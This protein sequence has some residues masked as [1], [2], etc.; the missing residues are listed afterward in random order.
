MP[1]LLGNRLYKHV[2][3]T[4]SFRIG[5]I[6]GKTK[7]VIVDFETF[8]G[9]NTEEV[10]ENND[11][12]IKAII[13]SPISEYV[14]NAVAFF[15]E[16]I[17]TRNK[18][19][20]SSSLIKL[21]E[22]IIEKMPV[23]GTKIKTWLSHALSVVLEFFSYITESV[24]NLIKRHATNVFRWFSDKFHT[25][26]QHI[27]IIF[28]SKSVIVHKFVTGPLNLTNSV[29]HQ[30][31]IN[32]M[33]L[34]FLTPQTLSS[35]PIP[36]T[37]FKEMLDVAHQLVC[38]IGM[39]GFYGAFD[40]IY[41]MVINHARKHIVGLVVNLAK[42]INTLTNEE[43]LRA[44]PEIRKFFI[45]C[46]LTT[47]ARNGAKYN[48]YKT[49]PYALLKLLI[50]DSLR[51]KP[52]F[53][54]FLTD[55]W[56]WALQVIKLD[57]FYQNKLSTRHLWATMSPFIALINAINH[58]EHGQQ[59]I[60]RLYLINMIQDI[61]TTHMLMNHFNHEVL[62]F[63]KY[64]FNM[65][66][67]VDNQNAL[68]KEI[69][70]DKGGR[71]DLMDKLNIHRAFDLYHANATQKQDKIGVKKNPQRG[72]TKV[73]IAASSTDVIPE[74]PEEKAETAMGL[75][76]KPLEISTNTA[77][78]DKLSL[79]SRG[80]ATVEAQQLLINDRTNYDKYILAMTRLVKANTYFTLSPAVV[81]EAFSENKQYLIDQIQDN[82]ISD[83]MFDI[84]LQPTIDTYFFEYAFDNIEDELENI[85]VSIL[86]NVTLLASIQETIEAFYKQYQYIM[87]TSIS[88]L[89]HTTSSSGIDKIV[90]YVTDIVTEKCVILS[91]QCPE[92]WSVVSDVALKSDG[93]EIGTAKAHQYAD[94][95][96][97]DV[98]KNSHWV[99]ARVDGVMAK[100]SLRLF[101]DLNKYDMIAKKI[102]NLIDI[103]STKNTI[104]DN[105]LVVANTFR[106][107]SLYSVM[108]SLHFSQPN[109]HESS[110]HTHIRKYIRDVSAEIVTRSIEEKNVLQK[111]VFYLMDLNDI[112][113]YKDMVERVFQFSTL[114]LGLSA[115]SSFMT[116]TDA[117]A[118]TEN[119][120]LSFW[121]QAHTTQAMTSS[122]GIS[123][124][125]IYTSS[126]IGVLVK[127]QKMSNQLYSYLS[128]P[129]TLSRINTD[130]RELI[131]YSFTKILQN[132]DNPPSDALR[133][134]MD[135]TMRPFSA[136]GF[137]ATS[138]SL[139]WS[140][141]TFSPVMLLING[142]T[143]GT[144]GM[145]ME[146]VGEYMFPTMKTYADL[147]AVN[148]DTL[149]G[150]EAIYS[151][152][153][154]V[155]ELKKL[156]VLN[157]K[158]PAAVL[159]QTWWDT[160]VDTVV[161]APGAAIK[162]IF[163]NNNVVLAEASNGVDRL[164]HLHEIHEKVKWHVTLTQQISKSFYF[165][166]PRTDVFS[167]VFKA[168][169][170]GF[171]GFLTNLYAI[172]MAQDFAANNIKFYWY[173]CIGFIVSVCILCFLVS[174]FVVSYYGARNRFS[175]LTKE[176]EKIYRLL[177][178]NSSIL[179]GDGHTSNVQEAIGPIISLFD[180]LFFALKTVTIVALVAFIKVMS[181]LGP[182]MLIYL[183]WVVYSIISDTMST[184]WV[185]IISF[186]SL[187]FIASNIPILRDIDIVSRIIRYVPCFAIFM[188][189][190]VEPFKRKLTGI[191][192]QL[193][194]TISSVDVRPQVERAFEEINAFQ[195]KYSTTNVNAI[196][197]QIAQIMELYA[198]SINDYKKFS[199]ELETSSIPND[200]SSYTTN[201]KIATKT[202]L[203]RNEPK[204]G[205]TSNVIVETLG[206]RKPIAASSSEPM[207]RF[208]LNN[209]TIELQTFFRAYAKN[210]NLRISLGLNNNE[211]TIAGPAS[212]SQQQSL[213]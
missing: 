26:F 202:L 53:V 14:D 10:F 193:R 186:F 36:D 3:K 166:F 179:S 74:E 169:F 64:L 113:L 90:Q 6:F 69:H 145:L 114:G 144:A 46:F 60:N 73:P 105:S 19:T 50:K 147:V 206:T 27:L 55:L 95:E 7:E 79:I 124:F 85:D 5:E 83:L 209:A 33:P 213:K 110:L 142:A 23:V 191:T 171:Y 200:F 164:K 162:W 185:V 170:Q 160:I 143:G 45:N 51:D 28:K 78:N 161:S 89:H 112:T 178:V 198:T 29:F 30:N 77:L 87:K 165:N 176:R 211:L 194:T 122:D 172:F 68:L 121:H 207:E 135:N 97:F 173:I 204:V 72:K 62:V 1:K 137:A 175:L 41:G 101:N 43:C 57:G 47:D 96:R 131:N 203:Q 17:T 152:T 76:L 18:K 4:N 188:D 25:V 15:D 141:M 100:F 192:Q 54:R 163:S 56:A 61:K 91:K 205:W 38:Y 167:G 111:C 177:N 109:T 183:M 35:T 82:D 67:F 212:S 99:K 106:K 32:G 108:V 94:K 181:Y 48:Y 44:T 70:F 63:D 136:S 104:N 107:I 31:A 59:L 40:A 182:I 118:L 208:N 190:F 127:A 88:C 52:F 11:D 116:Y 22:I 58:S 154:L 151:N 39:Y 201:L 49:R 80:R 42:K 120:Q 133:A 75:Y 16:S 37:L 146:K 102:H 119:E 155:D 180:S 20:V 157:E 34:E 150:I 130:M 153:T 9:E 139:S 98:I 84:I 189:F 138:E 128:N 126:D 81:K 148:Q 156:I 140:K 158:L 86:D 174:M 196:K 184:I 65:D 149:P 12:V 168:L 187:P 8:S 93:I 199:A 24:W 197:H 71:V 92:Y 123:N 129:A 66:T 2:V 103:L 132:K 13:N 125:N 134:L 21:L 159:D 195:L 117:G 115:G 210:E